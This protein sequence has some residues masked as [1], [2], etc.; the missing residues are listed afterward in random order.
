MHPAKEGLGMMG[1]FCMRA[2]G[3]Y[4]GERGGQVLNFSVRNGR[5]LCSLTSCFLLVWCQCYPSPYTIKGCC[6]WNTIIVAATVNWIPFACCPE[7]FFWGFLFS[8]APNFVINFTN[9]AWTRAPAELLPVCL[10]QALGTEVYTRLRFHTAGLLPQLTSC[11]FQVLG[12]PVWICSNQSGNYWPSNTQ[13]W[14]LIEKLQSYQGENWYWKLSWFACLEKEFH[15]KNH[16]VQ[17]ISCKLCICTVD[18]HIIYST[19]GW[20]TCVFSIRR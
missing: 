16:L 11:I 13:Y 14:K 20:G 19:K 2:S 17:N 15:L 18:C 5:P 12:F 4:S 7:N 9:L 1:E 6:K 8:T 10:E 3:Y